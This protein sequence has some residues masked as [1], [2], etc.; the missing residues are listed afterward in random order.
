MTSTVFDFKSVKVSKK[1]DAVSGLINNILIADT[2][3]YNAY[4]RKKKTRLMK[5]DQRA[6]RRRGRSGIARRGGEVTTK[7]AGE[8]LD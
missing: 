1:G 2:M 8:A 6:D 5:R 4:N 7:R 3:T